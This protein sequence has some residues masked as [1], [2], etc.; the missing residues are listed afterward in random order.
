MANDYKILVTPVLKP[1]AMQGAID[2]EAKTMSNSGSNAGNKFGAS[3]NSAFRK[4]ISYAIIDL[5]RD[6]VKDMVSNVMELDKAQTELKKVTDLTGN[7]LKKFTNQAYQAGKETARTGT[8]MVQASTEF[9]K[10]GI[11]EDQLMSYAKA[12][13]MFQNIADSEISAGDAASFIY[14]QMKAFSKEGITATQ[15]LDKINEVSNNFGVSSTD[16]S[17]ALTKTASAFH[18]Y[19]NDMNNTLGIITAGVEMMPKQASKVARG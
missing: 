19:G 17:Q 8:E 7:S 9:A 12:A 5:A 15:V 18:N 3:F 2:A 1:G 16:L 4:T 6:A 10:M 11:P 14:S 13:T